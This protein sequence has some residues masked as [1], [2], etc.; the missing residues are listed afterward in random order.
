MKDVKNW[1]SKRE[2]EFVEFS[3]DEVLYFV[4]PF[5]VIFYDIEQKQYLISFDIAE[6]KSFC[7]EFFFDLQNDFIDKIDFT[8]YY[9]C[10]FLVDEFN[11]V[12]FM[13]FDDK[14]R[15]HYYQFIY[16]FVLSGLEVPK[17]VTV[18]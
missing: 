11:Q 4:T 18:H 13:Y 6:D 16:H 3:K 8:V 2:I 15:E 17:N 10:C 12:E 9:D 5:C 14:A 7:M 1:L